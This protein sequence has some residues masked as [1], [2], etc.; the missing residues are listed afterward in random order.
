MTVR[1]DALND[2]L[3][4]NR[5]QF[6]DD[7]RLRVFKAFLRQCF[8]K[9]RTEYEK[10][11]KWADSGRAIVQSYGMLPLLSFR[12]FVEDQLS[13]SGNGLEMFDSAGD[14][15]EELK[16][17]RDVTKND[18]RE[19]LKGVD[20][21][22][23]GASAPLV[24][25][26]LQS[27]KVLVNS[28]HP[29][30]RE[31]SEDAGEKAAIK[32]AVLVDLLTDVHAHDLGIDSTQ[33]E[34]LRQKRDRVARMVA[35]IHRRSGAQIAS[36]LREV[37]K[38][39]DWRALEIIVGDALEYLGL[40]VTR[41]SG[42]GEPEGIARA[43]LPPNKQGQSQGYSF[44]YDAKSSQSG[45][46]QTGNCNVAGLTRHRDNHEVDYILLVAP[47][48]QSGALEEECQKFVVTPITAADL[49]NM[50]LLSAEYGAIPLTKL[51]ELFDHYTPKGVSD[52]VTD[53]Q[54]WMKEQRRLTLADLIQTLGTLEEG[55]P[56]TVSVSVLADRCR[57]VA[58][59]K[60]TEADVRR[61][62]TG[63]QI[64]VPDLI[65]VENDKVVINA[66]PTKL[67]EAITTQ[68]QRIKSPEGQLV[69]PKDN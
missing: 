45:K 5:E 33:L 1:A 58:K 2:L 8:N 17:Y 18:V 7:K 68:L 10:Q 39:P 63:L 3:S 29:F 12:D 64:L 59:R 53:L 66:H 40:E 49:G 9:A 21:S 35:K 42:S 14:R 51:K 31:H 27:R 15:E 25:Y 54:V 57:T 65:Q 16:T 24:K 62:L 34:E 13:E 52:W 41:I 36:L 47:D 46:A 32:D 6:T 4:V 60:V 26:S 19:V 44:S 28:D 43:K 69:V 38:H 67:A 55:F 23:F 30:V 11:D 20:F 48:F 22:R 61:V 50:L 37:S 56:D